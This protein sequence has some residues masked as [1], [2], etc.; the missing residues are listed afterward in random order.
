MSIAV[1]KKT[2]P[3]VVIDRP[4]TA[5]IS[6]SKRTSSGIVVDQ[7]TIETSADIVIRRGDS[8]IRKIQDIKNVNA[9]D[10]QDG[11]ALLYDTT[12][13]K[14]VASPNEPDNLD[15]GYY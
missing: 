2:A 1:T 7:N 15:G 5:K 14:W 13:E 10:L 9:N 8:D 3:R 4:A 6:I 12:T 11:Y